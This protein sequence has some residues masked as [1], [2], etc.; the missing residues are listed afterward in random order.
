MFFFFGQPEKKNS[1]K[2]RGVTVRD[3]QKLVIFIISIPPVE[4]FVRHALTIFVSFSRLIAERSIMQIHFY[5]SEQIPKRFSKEQRVWP[6]M[7]HSK[8]P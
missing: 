8:N 1:A 3:R 5:L 4:H 7:N 2:D 6:A